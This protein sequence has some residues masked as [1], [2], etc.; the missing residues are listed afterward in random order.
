MTLERIRELKRANPF[1]PFNLVLVDGRKLPVEKS[2]YIG[3]SPSK[4]FV[5]HSSLDGGYEVIRPEQVR[6]IDFAVEEQ[7]SDNA[8]QQG[9]A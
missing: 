7:N 3:I 6:E 9:A 4:R 2:Y 5:T 1:R 8:S